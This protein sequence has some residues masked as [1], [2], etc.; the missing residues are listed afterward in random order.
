[1]Q[2]ARKNEVPYSQAN[3]VSGEILRRAMAED[4]IYTLHKM[5]FISSFAVKLPKLGL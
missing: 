5:T 3:L 4:R 1:M 2:N